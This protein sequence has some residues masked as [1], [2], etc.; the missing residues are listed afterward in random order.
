MAVAVL[1]VAGPIPPKISGS[2]HSEPDPLIRG[3]A[4]WVVFPRHISRASSW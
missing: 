4:A 1:A 3:R 2:S